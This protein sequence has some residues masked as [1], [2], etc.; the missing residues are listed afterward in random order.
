MRKVWK[1]EQFDQ[2]KPSL[3]KLQQLFVSKSLLHYVISYCTLK[4]VVS[5]CILITNLVNNVDFSI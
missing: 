4:I 2:T 5:K 1:L 3:I